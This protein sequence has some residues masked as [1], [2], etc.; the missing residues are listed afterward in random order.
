VGLHWH[1]RTISFKFALDER[2]VGRT[3]ERRVH[4]RQDD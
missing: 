2:W 1:S 3:T 4:G